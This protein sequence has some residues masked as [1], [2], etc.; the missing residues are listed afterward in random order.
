MIDRDAICAELTFQKESQKSDLLDPSITTETLLTFLS[1]LLSRRDGIWKGKLVVTSVKSDHD[2][3]GPNGHFGGNALD[4]AAIQDDANGHLIAD[5]Q[6][7]E[8]ARGIGLSPYYWNYVPALGGFNEA[9]KLFADQGG[10][11]IH[12]QVVGY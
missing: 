10:Q 7:C 11:H 3:D 2:D 5:A 9:S 4:F 12:V 1:E 6:A 8:D